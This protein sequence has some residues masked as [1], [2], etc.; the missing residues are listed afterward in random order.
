MLEKGTET[1]KENDMS[2]APYHFSV[3][4]FDRGVR[5]RRYQRDGTVQPRGRPSR[6]RGRR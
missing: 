6:L 2:P 5:R 1:E 4:D 3:L